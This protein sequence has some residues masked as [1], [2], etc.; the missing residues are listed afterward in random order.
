MA[1]FINPDDKQKIQNILTEI[2]NSMTRTEA[3]ADYIKECLLRMEDEFG[4]PK[5]YMRKV[6]RIFHKQNISEEQAN[7][8][9][10]S[11]IYESIVG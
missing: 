11:D 10:V 9:E 1:N 3:E 6:A 7:F 4:L 2:S 8:E 5:K